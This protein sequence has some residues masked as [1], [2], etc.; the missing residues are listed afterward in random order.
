MD[1]GS[2]PEIQSHILQ[3]DDVNFL[4]RNDVPHS[5]TSCCHV[6]KKTL[7]L[8]KKGETDSLNDYVLWSEDDFLFCPNPVI[9]PPEQAKGEDLLDF[10]INIPVDYTPSNPVSDQ[11][12]ALL[13]SIMLLNHNKNIKIAQL[14]RPVKGNVFY[15]DILSSYRVEWKYLNHSKMKQYYYTNWPFIC[16]RDL[17]LSMADSCPKTGSIERYE[18]FARDWWDRKFGETDDYIAAPKKPY[19][20][21][22]GYSFSQQPLDNRNKRR[23]KAFR[24]LQRIIGK[25][26]DPFK[27]NR[28]L[29]RAF[30]NGDLKFDL[31]NVEAVGLQKH[32]QERLL[33]YSCTHI[34]GY[35][36]YS[37]YIKSQQSKAKSIQKKGDGVEWEKD[38]VYEIKKKNLKRV[39]KDF[40]LSNCHSALVLGA[41]FGTDI[42]ILKKFGIKDVIGVDIYHPPLREDILICDAHDLSSLLVKDFDLVF[43]H[44]VFEHFLHPSKV[45]GEIFRVLN[46][47]GIVVVATPPISFKNERKGNDAQIELDGFDDLVQL[48]EDYNF[49]T[50][51]NEEVSENNHLFVFAKSKK[52]R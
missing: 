50:K 33:D 16:R 2:D 36:V 17:L 39:N 12:K 49:C 1:D 31:D 18:K 29:S 37:S 38:N 24:D 35:N 8:M 43:C 9:L 45:V 51:I 25:K 3:R 40:K 42:D 52:I 15:G 13:S 7:D 41:R 34:G 6:I 20:I 26:E 22:I 46:S 11:Y 4:V 10:S 28:R 21:H 30:L 14:S 47:K 44:H 48:F 5:P 23:Q 27:I 19:Y 32:M